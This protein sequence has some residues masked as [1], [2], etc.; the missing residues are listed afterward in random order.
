MVCFPRLPAMTV[1]P[2]PFYLKRRNLGFIAPVFSIVPLIIIALFSI[3]HF[4]GVD[5]SAASG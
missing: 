4:D 3:S 5:E 2:A 1:V